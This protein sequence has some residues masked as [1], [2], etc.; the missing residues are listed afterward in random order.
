MSELFNSSTYDSNPIGMLPIYH[1]NFSQIIA[2][3]V[4]R[5]PSVSFQY[6]DEEH[7]FRSNAIFIKH[8]IQRHVGLFR[9]SLDGGEDMVEDNR[10][11]DTNG[12][13]GDQLKIVAKV[14]F[15]LEV[16]AQ[17]N[18][19][20]KVEFTEIEMKIMFSHI[21]IYYLCI[22]YQMPAKCVVNNFATLLSEPT[23]AQSMN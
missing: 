1:D 18:R 19:H 14:T 9:E 10:C 7:L 23:D 13:T 21:R 3:V 20:I 8:L 12:A 17:V 11:P 16:V 4:N 5:N 6:F 22:Y 2:S 15:A